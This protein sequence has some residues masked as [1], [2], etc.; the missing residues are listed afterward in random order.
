MRVPAFSSLRSRQMINVYFCSSFSQLRL[1]VWTIAV[2]VSAAAAEIKSFIHKSLKVDGSLPV[3]HKVTTCHI[4]WLWVE[5][6]HWF[7]LKD[8]FRVSFWNGHI[9]SWVISSADVE[10]A[11]WERKLFNGPTTSLSAITNKHSK[12]T[13]P[14]WNPVYTICGHLN[15]F[16][17]QIT[18]CLES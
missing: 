12:S 2:V 13:V 4:Y 14:N 10:I 8:I 17:D 15:D 6:G 16:S 7:Y 1:C 11:C 18:I 9:C 5:R 3:N